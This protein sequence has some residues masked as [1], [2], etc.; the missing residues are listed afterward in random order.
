MAPGPPGVTPVYNSASSKRESPVGITLMFI[1]SRLAVW[2]KHF[3][4]QTQWVTENRTLTLMKSLQFYTYPAVVANMWRN[5]R[6]ITF[7]RGKTE[8]RDWGLGLH[9]KIIKMLQVDLLILFHL[10][11]LCNGQADIKCRK[12]FVRRCH[13]D[14]IWLSFQNEVLKMICRHFN[15]NNHSTHLFELYTHSN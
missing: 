9:S 1:M 6:S 13:A 10:T 12:R 4:S 8:K 3:A 15:Y 2:E 7:N 5:C 14:F 11:E